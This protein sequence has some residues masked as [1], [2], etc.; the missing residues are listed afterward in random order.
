MAVTEYNLGDVVYLTWAT[1]DSTGAPAAT[2][3]ALTVTLPDGTTSSPAVANPSLG[4]YTANYAPTTFGRHVYKWAGTVTNPQVLVDEFGVRDI[5]LTPIISIDDAKQHLNIPTAITTD[6]A[7]LRRFIDYANDLAESYCG[8]VLGR[9]TFAGEIYDGGDTFIRL[10]S[11]KAMSITSITE[12][13]TA[14]VS[15]TDYYLDPTGQRVFRLNNGTYFPSNQ[16]GYW[17]TGSQNIVITYVSGFVNPPNG[18]K[19]GMLDLVRHLWMTQRGG[20]VAIL[21]T[22]DSF[23]PGGMHV[24]TYR[25]S[26]ALGF[27][28]LPGIL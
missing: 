11:P 18:A 7:E 26:E 4:S 13:S 8:V 9:R 14:L 12:N 5:T 17:A 6:D 15:G 21:Q 24:F 25:I 3:A 19:L 10:R 28:R 23:I 27:L 22:D 1:V 2:T 16:V 20:K